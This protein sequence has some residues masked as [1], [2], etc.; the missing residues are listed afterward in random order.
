MSNC[1][2]FHCFNRS[3]FGFSIDFEPEELES[4]TIRQNDRLM[5]RFDLIFLDKSNLS[6]LLYCKIFS[7]S[8]Q[9]TGNTLIWPAV[10][11]PSCILRYCILGYCNLGIRFLVHLAIFLK[12][13]FIIKLSYFLKK[14]IA[15]LK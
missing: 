6:I 7:N 14:I 4:S 2:V 15:F 11:W 1:D 13:Y 5:K 10:F 12:L 3:D 8:G 9:G